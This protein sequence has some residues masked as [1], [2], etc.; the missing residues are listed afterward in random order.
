[1]STIQW[2][3]KGGRPGLWPRARSEKLEKS[4]TK[5]RKFFLKGA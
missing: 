4:H 1:M 2:R 5:G 3:N